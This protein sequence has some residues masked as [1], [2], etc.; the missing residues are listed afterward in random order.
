MELLGKA[1]MP[2]IRPITFWVILGQGLAQLQHLQSFACVSCKAMLWM[3]QP[4]VSCCSDG[5]ALLGLTMPTQ[6]L[7]MVMPPLGSTI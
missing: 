2:E 1:N 3:G 4:P 6:Y 7:D 5:M